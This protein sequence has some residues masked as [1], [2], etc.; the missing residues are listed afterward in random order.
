[1]T[2]V[3]SMPHTCSR[4][5]LMFRADFDVEDD[6]DKLLYENILYNDDYSFYTITGKLCFKCEKGKDLVTYGI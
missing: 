1:M 4:C 2:K 6:N 5:G 3:V